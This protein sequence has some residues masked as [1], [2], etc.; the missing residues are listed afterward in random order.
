MALKPAVGSCQG[1]SNFVSNGCHER[2]PVSFLLTHN[3]AN[4]QQY[5]T[6]HPPQ[7]TILLFTS[8]THQRS[9]LLCSQMSGCLVRQFAALV[10]QAAPAASYVASQSL[11]HAQQHKCYYNS[12]SSDNSAEADT[13]QLQLQ[14]NTSTSST[15]F[16]S[17]S[18]G[19]WARSSLC[20]SRSSSDSSI[21]S[22]RG[23]ASVSRASAHAG[24]GECMCWS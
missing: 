10:Q 7:T 18:L 1:R 24:C 11:Q 22:A 8:N 9:M 6:P 20:L 19:L 12:S 16:N 3:N 5:K 21:A 13:T 4:K 2:T 23:F 15:T 14:A 17:S